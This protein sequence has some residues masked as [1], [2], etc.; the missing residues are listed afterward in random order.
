MP[1]WAVATSSE[2]RHGVLGGIE[3][4][5]R[6]LAGAANDRIAGAANVRGSL[7]LRGC[8]RFVACLLATFL[9]KTAQNGLAFNQSGK[10]PER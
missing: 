1:R 9:L 8:R 7:R 6:P 10:R 4:R 5:R 2:M 3:A